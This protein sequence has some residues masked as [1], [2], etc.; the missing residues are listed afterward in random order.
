MMT[1]IARHSR[2]L[3]VMPAPSPSCPPPLRHARPLSV[4]PGRDRESM[5]SWIPD[6][7]GDDGKVTE[8]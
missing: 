5:H 1:T 2:P 8:S 4:I 6:Q 7:V 3:S